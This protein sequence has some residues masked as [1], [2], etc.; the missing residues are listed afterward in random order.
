MIKKFLIA[1]SL[2]WL[3]I[4]ATIWIINMLVNLFDDIINVLPHAYRPDT[5]LGFHIPGLGIIIAVL[6]VLVTGVLVTNILGNKLMLWLDSGLKR[7]P[8]IGGLYSTIKQVFSTVISSDGKSFRK[9]LLIEYPKA[10]L[11][12][13]AFQ[14]GEAEEQFNIA[15]N[16]QMLTAFIP[17]TPNP[18][19]GF[20]ILVPK[21]KAIELD[22]SVEQAFKVI[23][24]LGTLTADEINNLKS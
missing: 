6:I 24:S 10:G 8:L 21:D 18:T 23:V 2:V 11:W 19:S 22:M 9:V 1:G 3:P 15:L 5:L 7:I 16:Q 14:T 13:L 20:L 17:T 4:I 12:S